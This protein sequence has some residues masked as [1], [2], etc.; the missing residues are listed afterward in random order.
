MYATVPMAMPCSVSA[1][2]SSSAVI[3]RAIPKSAT[4][5]RPAA[6]KMFSGLM[7]RWTTPLACA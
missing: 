4:S 6:V 3:A 2:W 7:S 5:A 1:V